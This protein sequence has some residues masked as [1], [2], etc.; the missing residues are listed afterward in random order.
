VGSIWR[1]LILAP[2]AFAPSCSKA[3]A[4]SC[5]PGTSLRGGTCIV[6][7][8]TTSGA[9]PSNAPQTSDAPTGVDRFAGL[10]KKQSLAEAIEVVRPSMSDAIDSW[11]EGGIALAAWAIQHLRWPDVDI[12]KNETSF[13]LVKKDSD[14]ARGKKMCTA[15]ELVQ[16]AKEGAGDTTIYTGLLINAYG[17]IYSF[18]VAGDTGELVANSRARLCG[19]VIGT[20]DYH[21][22][23]GGMGHAVAVV[24]MFDLPQNK[25]L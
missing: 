9:A 7:T 11:S 14:A 1:I 17:N 18:Y 22:S 3:D 4:V 15:G 19:V 10:M 24:G 23:G 21:N 13:A 12:N 6:A 25:K 16:I 2:L 8:T 20:Y 5:G